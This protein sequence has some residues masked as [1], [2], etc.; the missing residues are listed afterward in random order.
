MSFF[1]PLPR[2]TAR[3]CAWEE[4]QGEERQRGRWGGVRG[5]GAQEEGEGDDDG[6]EE[7]GEERRRERWAGDRE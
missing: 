1:P 2:F 7:E 5:K 4:T 6:V 3:W